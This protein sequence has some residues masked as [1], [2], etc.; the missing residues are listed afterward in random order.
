MIVNRLFLWCRT[1]LFTRAHACT[2]PPPHTHTHTHTTPMP[3][4]SN[5]FQTGETKASEF[6]RVCETMAPRW[7]H[8]RTVTGT[9]CS[10]EINRRILRISHLWNN[11]FTLVWLHPA[12]RAGSAAPSPAPSP[13]ISLSLSLSS[14]PLCTAVHSDFLFAALFPRH[15][16]L[17][18]LDMLRLKYEGPALS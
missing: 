13:Y 18:E 1:S 11:L 7:H 15:D 6:S 8:L 2:H 5:W 16:I 3:L 9:V 4:V 10:L 12:G 14:L 17:R